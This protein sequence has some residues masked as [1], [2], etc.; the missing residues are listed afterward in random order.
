M[1]AT[2]PAE[3]IRADAQTGSRNDLLSSLH[4][5]ARRLADDLPGQLGR[6]RVCSGDVAIEIEWLTQPA[7]VFTEARIP[8]SATATDAGR[9]SGAEAAFVTSP[10]V[11]TFYRAPEPNAEPYVKVGDAVEPGQVVG[12]VEA[13][14]LMN[15]VTVEIGGT[16]A[17]ICADNG[18]AVEYDQDLVEITPHR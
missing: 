1:K 4:D 13:M 2:Q 8:N 11:G 14:K 15:P 17:R 12:V 7:A 16:V 3:T 6:I 18:E 9:V 5:H 10:L